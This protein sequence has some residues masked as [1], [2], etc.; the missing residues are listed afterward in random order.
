MADADED[1]AAIAPL[2]QDLRCDGTALENPP[3]RESDLSRPNR[4]IWAL[5]LTAG[6]SGL[7][8]GYECDTLPTQKRLDMARSGF[9][10]FAPAPV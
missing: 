2:I 1:E 9:L 7:L 3:P 10:K 6:I 5:T 4:F 8:F